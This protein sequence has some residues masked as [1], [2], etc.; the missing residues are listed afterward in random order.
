MAFRPFHASIAWLL[1]GLSALALVPA[2]ALA[3]P[4]EAKV[5]TKSTARLQADR[6]YEL[7]EAGKFA[8]A[9]QAFRQAEAIFHAP[10]LVF[11]IARAESKA[12]HL[13]E[14]R[15]LYKQV[16][17]EKLAPSAPPE[18]QGAQE[19]S[20][21]ELA[22]LEARI[23]HVVITVNGG[24]GRAFVVSLDENV[25]GISA[26]EKPIEVDPGA[27]QLVVLP[28]HGATE[29]RTVTVVEGGTESVAIDLPPPVIHAL[30]GLRPPPQS[31]DLLKPALLSLGA[32][33]AGIGIG[34]ILGGITL[35]KASEI[36]SHCAGDVCPAAQRSAADSAGTTATISTVA[37]IVGG[38]FAATGGA[39]L[40][41]RSR[42]RAP[43]V[44]LALAPGALFAQGA[45]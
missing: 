5:E 1:C 4:P 40:V 28:D 38:V 15:T 11:A 31:R 44:G 10:T 2:T 25:V 14:A 30:D 7:F 18:F 21:G 43:S 42:S 27:H 34:A 3:A 29:K 39:L 37:F 13:L 35:S 19:S 8:E 12:G 26:L 17:A 32:G 33:A 6:G 9:A 20:R 24:A 22:T 36:K 45:F 41:L 16:I 23:A